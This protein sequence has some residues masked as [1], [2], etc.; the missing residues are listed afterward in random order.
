M[1]EPLQLLLLARLACH[2]R[3]HGAGQHEH[4]IVVARD[5]IAEQHQHP[6]ATNGY[7]DFGRDML[8]GVLRRMG[9]SGEHRQLQRA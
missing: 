9:A 6:T 3:C 4:A 2:L 1:H 5:H 8:R 7:V